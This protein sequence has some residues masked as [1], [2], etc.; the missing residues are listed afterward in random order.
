MTPKSP[1][2]IL[3][4]ICKYNDIWYYIQYTENIT[5]E[6]YK[7]TRRYIYLYILIGVKSV[8]DSIV[9]DQNV[10][11]SIAHWDE[12]Y[13]IC[14]DASFRRRPERQRDRERGWRERERSEQKKKIFDMVLRNRLWRRGRRT[15]S[16]TVT[17]RSI[18][19]VLFPNLSK[20][21]ERRKK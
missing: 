17:A 4:E 16:E 2:A 21:S 19:I 20:H 18:C 11:Y 7:N 8:G 14:V 6:K 5:Y 12:V 9:A 3:N 1:N 15:M 13:A 10:V